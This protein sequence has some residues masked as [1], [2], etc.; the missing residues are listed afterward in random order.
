MSL[1]LSQQG[2]PKTASAAF[3]GTG[4]LSAVAVRIVV[5]SASLAGAGH[6][7]A[8]AVRIRTASATLAGAGTLSATP[9]VIHAAS[10]S[11]VGRGTLS[12]TPVKLGGSTVIPGRPPALHLRVPDDR[13]AA[14]SVTIRGHFY[15]DPVAR[16]RVAAKA[17]PLA[18]V[19]GR[20]TPANTSRIAS[21][22][23]LRLDVAARGR[24]QPPEVGAEDEDL[25]LLAALLLQ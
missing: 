21:P 22:L 4:L 10:A 19:R 12:A 13:L 5:A 24:A 8:T 23:P 7:S 20:A 16:I 6:L 2:G 15:A 17:P 1:L 18:V 11:F 14:A 25:L 3:V 9:T